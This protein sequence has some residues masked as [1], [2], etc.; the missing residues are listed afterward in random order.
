[1]TTSQALEP[2]LYGRDPQKNTVIE[3]ITNVE[4]IHRNLTVIPI[5]G[6]GGIGKTT[7]TQYI[8]NNKKV[9]DHFEIRVWACVSL[10]FSV[11]KLTREI[12]GSIPKAE[13]E[14]NDRPD[15]EVQNLDQLQKLIE[16]R[17]KSRRFLLVLDD[18]WKYGN[19]AE[20]NKFLVPFKKAQGNGDTVLLGPLV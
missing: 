2:T 8:Y 9:Q 6:P 15:S 4:Y 11:H 1:V 18:I 16:K 3:D 12:V 14:K 10:D 7:L 19:E 13:D 5:V 17:L 20:W